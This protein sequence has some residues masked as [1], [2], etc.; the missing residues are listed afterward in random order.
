MT[1]S[2]FR[3]PLRP[4]ARGFRGPGRAG[5]ARRGARAS[6]VPRA[7]RGARTTGV[8]PSVLRAGCAAVLCASLAIGVGARLAAA[9]EAAPA[10]APPL[11][12]RGARVLD[13]RAG[14]TGPPRDILIAGGV[15]AALG[16]P[17][18]EAGGAEE[19][20]CAGKVALP[21]LFDCHTHLAH[22]TAGGEDSLRRGLRQFVE[23]GV[24]HARD[25]GGPI[26][27]LSD[28][29]RRIAAGEL[30]GPE[31]F[32]SG[33]MLESSPLTWERF[34][35]S[36][37]GFTVAIDDAADADSLL[38]ELARRG[39]TMIKTF[40]R[41]D[42]PLYAQVVEVARRCSLRVVHDPGTPLFHWMPMDEA[43][44]LGVT[45]FEHAKSPW[46][47]VLEDSLRAQHDLATGPGA[48]PMRQMAVMMRAVEQGVGGI[49]GER[50]R[51]LAERMAARGALLCPTLHVFI[52]MAAEGGEAAPGGEEIPEARRAMMKKVLSA[53]EAI[54]RHLTGELAR[55]G[56]RMLVG[57]DGASGAATLAE[58]RHLRDCGVPAA[59]VI[60]G[61]TLYPAEWLGVDD[62]LGTIAVG[63]E[64]SLLLLDADP[65]ADIDGMESTFL[66][67][68]RGRIVS[69]PSPS[70]VD[71]GP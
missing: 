55:Y 16:E 40:N 67:V 63:R 20:D 44:E 35:E 42:K 60:R 49:S 34:N 31:V 14:E 37:P 64:A 18:M 57:Q 33:P 54:S 70:P 11:V 41:I 1:K 4:P 10:G 51:E 25:V 9:R 19:V 36:L 58:M 50:V 30:E 23:R 65:L 32:F 43:L 48:D 45:S 29:N 27:L 21:G 68:Q 38:P 3:Q 53:M 17:G 56:V 15:I 59:E 5:R 8:S 71:A 61:A 66:V 28:L 22:L 6:R 24:L 26:D 13:V 12:L 39:A 52:A 62:R 69:R 47:V 7:P 2:C 46:P